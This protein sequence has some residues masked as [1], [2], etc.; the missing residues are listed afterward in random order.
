M[1]LDLRLSGI[2]CGGSRGDRFVLSWWK[3][4]SKGRRYWGYRKS[5]DNGP[6]S[7][8]DWWFGEVTWRLPWTQHDGGIRTTDWV[9]RKRRVR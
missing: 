2:A 6:L 4:L 8:F 5:W 9:L 1:K 3:R 7:H